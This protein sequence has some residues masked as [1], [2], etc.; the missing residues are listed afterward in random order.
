MISEVSGMIS[1]VSGTVI[2][3]ESQEWVKIRRSE[4]TH[5]PGLVP[6]PLSGS[7]ATL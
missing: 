3:G 5:L 4:K 7:L 1:E 2:P 6:F